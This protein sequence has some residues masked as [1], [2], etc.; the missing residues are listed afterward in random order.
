MEVLPLTPDSQVGDRVKWKAI[1]NQEFEGEL[2]EWDNYTA[3]I[4]LNNGQQKFVN[5]G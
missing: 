2:I 3:I 5:C 1:D 4:K